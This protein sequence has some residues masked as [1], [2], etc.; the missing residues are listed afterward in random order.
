MSGLFKKKKPKPVGLSPELFQQL[1]RDG[2]QADA[3]VGQGK[4]DE[5][6][7]L[8]GTIFRRMLEAGVADEFILAKLCLSSIQASI[9]RNQIQMAHAI[10]TGQL[11]GA[12]GQFYAMGIQAVDT[13]ILEVRDTLV[14]QTSCAFLHACN[15]DIHAAR[16]AVNGVMSGVLEAAED[17][18][19]NE[20]RESLISH[21]KYCLTR[22]F[23]DDPAP[24]DLMN[25]VEQSA[26]KL[27]LTVPEKGKLAIIK[28]S[29]WKTDTSVIG[30]A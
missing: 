29:D 5:G 20:Y 28:P 30:N 13:G 15:T 2:E 26:M 10:W 14:Y 18:G 16:K 6:Q 17:G 9:A 8:L 27:G 7:M 23:D 12:P 1:C 11:P 24:P 19:L 25:P 21:W 3:M 4:A 22:V